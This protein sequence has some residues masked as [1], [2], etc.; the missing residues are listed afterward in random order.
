M[1]VGTRRGYQFRSEDLIDRG[2]TL[3]LDIP[4]LPTVR[5]CVEVVEM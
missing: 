3:L 5:Y 4:I 1:A 2:R